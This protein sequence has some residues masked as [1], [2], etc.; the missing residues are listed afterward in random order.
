MSVNKKYEILR[1]DDEERSEI[2]MSMQREIKKVTNKRYIKIIYQS[3]PN[4]S[5]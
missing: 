1:T 2:I 5:Y 4:N 3:N